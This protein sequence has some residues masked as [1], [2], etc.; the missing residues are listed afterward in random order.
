VFTARYELDLLNKAV[1]ASSLKSYSIATIATKVFT[2]LTDIKLHLCL[3]L[4]SRVVEV[5][6]Y[7]SGNEMYSSRLVYCPVTF[8]IVNELS[9]HI[10][11]ETGLVGDNC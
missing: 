2:W 7:R 10:K 3:A 5:N 6:C 1:C 8:P 9:F 11:Q 4:A